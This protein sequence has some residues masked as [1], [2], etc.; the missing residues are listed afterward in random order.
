MSKSVNLDKKGILACSEEQAKANECKVCNNSEGASDAELHS[1]ARTIAPYRLTIEADEDNRFYCT[2]RVGDIF[3]TPI[4][5]GDPPFDITINIETDHRYS[6]NFLRLFN[7]KTEDCPDEFQEKCNQNIQVLEYTVLVK[8][9]RGLTLS[10][11]KERT[12]KHA[13]QTYV[14]E[15]V[16]YLSTIRIGEKIE[17]VQK[18]SVYVG[19]IGDI[20][21]V[22]NPSRKKGPPFLEPF[23]CP[24]FVERVEEFE[25]MRDEQGAP[26]IEGWELIR[27]DSDTS[28]AIPIQRYRAIPREELKKKTEEKGLGRYQNYQYD[29]ERKL[30]L[31]KF[32]NG[33]DPKRYMKS[34]R[35]VSGGGVVGL[36][37]PVFEVEVYE[38]KKS[39]N[40][41]LEWRLGMPRDEIEKR[42]EV[43]SIGNSAVIARTKGTKQS[44][45]VFRLI[46]PTD[47]LK[48]SIEIAKQKAFE[49]YEDEEGKEKE[50]RL[51]RTLA[52]PECSEYKL[53]P[54]YTEKKINVE[55]KPEKKGDLVKVIK[56]LRNNPKAQAKVKL[57]GEIGEVIWAPSKQRQTGKGADLV[58]VITDT[59]HEDTQVERM[60]LCM[61]IDMSG[62]MGDNVK[63]IRNQFNRVQQELETSA[64][65]TGIC[66]GSFVDDDIRMRVHL[67]N[68]NMMNPRDLFAV[69]SALNDII[70]GLTGSEEYILEAI[71]LALN[72]I[73]KIGNSKDKKKVIIL[74]D[75]RG[76]VRGVNGEEVLDSEGNLSRAYLP[77]L[78]RVKK[79]AKDLGVEF[80]IIFIDNS[81]VNKEKGD[82]K[83]YIEHIE[84]AKINITSMTLEQK[85]IEWRKIIDDP[86][87]IV[88][89]KREALRRLSKANTK[90]AVD[91]LIHYISHETLSVRNFAIKTLENHREE[92]VYKALLTFLEENPSDET[93]LE[94]LIN[95][96]D[97]KIIDLLFSHKFSPA[98]KDMRKIIKEFKSPGLIE[99]L[100]IDFKYGDYTRKLRAITFLGIRGDP[101][102][103]P[104]LIEIIEKEEEGRFKLFAIKALARIGDPKSIPILKKQ[105]LSKKESIRDTARLAL[106]SIEDKDALLS[107]LN[108]IEFKDISKK[109]VEALRKSGKKAAVPMFVK[110]LDHPSHE[111][112]RK[113]LRALIDF[114][115]QRAFDRL[116]KL[117]EKREYTHL[118]IIALGEIGDPR[119]I[120]ILS[121]IIQNRGENHID[122]LAALKSL[123]QIDDPM[124]LDQVIEALNNKDLRGSAMQ[125]I[126]EMDDMGGEK[127]VRA[128]FET[129]KRHPNAFDRQLYKLSSK[130]HYSKDRKYYKYLENIDLWLPLLEHNNDYI[131]LAAFRALDTIQNPKCID[132]LE[133]ILPKMK[134][135]DA[136]ETIDIFKN[137]KNK[138]A[139][140]ILISILEGSNKSLKIHVAS[141]FYNMESKYLLKQMLTRVDHRDP[142]VRGVAIR[143]IANSDDPKYEGVLI[144]RLEREMDEYIIID[145]LDGIMLIGR[146]LKERVE[147]A[148]KYI[149]NSNPE[150]RIKAVEL[151]GSYHTKKT[152]DIL[153]T[154]LKDSD[155]RVRQEILAYLFNRKDKFP[156]ADS[157]INMSYEFG[158]LE[159]KSY[160]AALS[161]GK[162]Y[163]FPLEVLLNEYFLY[164]YG[165][166]KEEKLKVFMEKAGDQAIEL[167]LLSL[168]SSEWRNRMAAAEALGLYAGPEI[169]APISELLTDTDSKVIQKA[170]EAID[171]IRER[172]ADQ[173]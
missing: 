17:G 26:V 124:A 33:K 45:Q 86:S 105:L 4:S 102:A 171:M 115:D 93:A 46:S 123:S 3:L 37:C 67:K 106:V 111:V 70:N 173:M 47:A 51:S 73:E 107:W 96:S 71:D 137:I 127:G 135:N 61:M 167:L 147:V 153:I 140:D 79:R 53:T 151:L 113:A 55:L 38:I 92:R 31:S 110:L 155:I 25:G 128:Y 50:V 145:C 83:Y 43:I 143:V 168:K 150:I 75:E 117:V 84:K 112:R 28:G 98:S 30:G 164:Y 52:D 162:D 126:E 103:L 62:S 19:V 63:N 69:D 88:P 132:H 152:T 80:K 170:T 139:I 36:E 172:A 74:T 169:I 12:L 146:G 40:T 32:M 29:L 13:K 60:L 148:M 41:C 136:K 1:Q 11:I 108:T 35:A 59:I 165:D 156:E 15:D 14:G 141:R 77:E 133:K 100:I 23:Y 64:R 2:Y 89:V 118:A 144:K 109:H 39:P 58:K 81:F 160:I 5:I 82:L 130:L 166:L 87:I 121:E 149:H 120:P 42:F 122:K 154:L 76:N 16:L 54:K 138:K 6:R 104:A 85:I 95:I 94:A 20:D 129:F 163:A 65:E 48:E 8:D 125:S 116:L 157:A 10:E 9:G 68:K 44:S 78:E 18:Y 66:V 24:E 57:W 161:E 22:D 34:L 56:I 159:T 90:E 131:R 72:E 142:L 134:L 49:L 119:A 99:K 114:S 27:L 101:K 7:G 158:D 91:L 21:I 97:L